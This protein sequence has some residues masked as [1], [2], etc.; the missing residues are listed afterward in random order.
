MMREKQHQKL[1]WRIV[2]KNKRKTRKE[3]KSAA[4]IRKEVNSER[5]NQKHK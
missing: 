3:K 5:K 2:N 4:K 1:S